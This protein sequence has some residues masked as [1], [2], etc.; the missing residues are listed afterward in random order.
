MADNA[1]RRG[2]PGR[3][4]GPALE[5]P[6]IASGRGGHHL[7]GPL[8]ALFLGDYD[9]KMGERSATFRLERKG[10]ASVEVSLPA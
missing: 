10:P 8:R 4:N 2:L 9:V 3:R 6:A 1:R 5:D 7:L